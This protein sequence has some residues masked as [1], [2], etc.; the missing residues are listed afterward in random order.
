MLMGIVMPSFRA[1]GFTLI[2]MMIVV[3]IIAIIA[4]VAYPNYTNFVM[5]GRRADGRELL[6]R[7]GAAQ[8]RFYTNNNRYTNNLADLSLGGTSEQGYYQ[9]QAPTVDA[10]GQTYTLTAV[11]QGPQAID[12]CGSLTLNNLGARGMSGNENNG[13]CW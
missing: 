11:P 7:I 8:E 9:V 12:K 2:E 13:K 5:R 6:M 10:T 4:A 1:R 3:A